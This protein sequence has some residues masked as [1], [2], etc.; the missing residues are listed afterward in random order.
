MKYLRVKDVL[1][2]YSKGGIS[3]V[4]NYLNQEGLIIEE[5]TWIHKI[6]TLLDKNLDKSVESEIEL[7][8]FEFKINDNRYEEKETK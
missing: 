1:K 3:F 7:L 8:L 6:K 4:K 2:Q 5:N